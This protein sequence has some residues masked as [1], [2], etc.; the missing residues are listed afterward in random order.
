MKLAHV[1]LFAALALASACNKNKPAEAPKAAAVP[2]AAEAPKAE[3]PKT[4][5]AT[6]AEAP[7][8]EEPKAPEAAPAAPEAAPAAPEAAPAAPEAAPAAPEAAPA[9]AGEVP[10]ALEMA[11]LELTAEGFAATMDA[12]KGA[13]A[14]DSFGTLEVTLGEGKDFYVAI[15]MKVDM[16]QI[17]KDIQSNDVQKLKA[18]ILDTPEALIYETDFAGNASFWMDSAVKVGEKTVRCYSGRGAHSFKKEQ[19]EL[20]LKACQ[21]MKPKA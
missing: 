10:V 5:E 19:V 4:E 17:K 21:S 7:E 6:K 20:F 2:K 11:S 12:P 15:D 3:A 8:A 1:S 9:A 18:F 14:A 16:V 13:V